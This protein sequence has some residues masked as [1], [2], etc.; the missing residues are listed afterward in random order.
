M[1]SSF[2]KIWRLKNVGTCTWKT[3]YRLVLVSGDLLG[4]QYLMPLP[5]EVA[6]GE[7]IDLAMKFKAP[8]VPGTYRGNWQIRNGDGEIFGTTVNANRPFSVAI[9]VETPATT[10]PAYNF[11]L[12]VCSAQWS[13]GAGNIRCPSVGA[14]ANGFILRQPITR[15]EDGSALFQPSFLVAPQNVFNGYISGVYPSF[16]VQ[17][18]DHLQAIIQCGYQATS[19]KVMFRVDYQLGDGTLQDFWE[20][21]EQYDEKSSNVDIDLSSLAGQEVRFVL[22]V[23]SVGQATGDRAVWVEPRIVRSAPPIVSTPTP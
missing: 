23:L 9:R 14:S 5:R 22:T 4:G 1:G 18:G 12:N 21:N 16:N 3:N 17:Q 7:T 19:C 6:P 13:S 8:Q 15:L 2:T 10:E 20:A 11:A